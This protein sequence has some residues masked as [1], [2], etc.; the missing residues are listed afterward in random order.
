MPYCIILERF[1][2]LDQH[3]ENNA[4]FIS[5]VPQPFA[6]KPIKTTVAA[7]IAAKPS[8]LILCKRAQAQSK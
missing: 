4:Y 5:K 7:I 2:M 1:G 3:Y 8:F 6:F